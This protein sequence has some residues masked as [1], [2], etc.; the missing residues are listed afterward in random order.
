M[1]LCSQYDHLLCKYRKKD[2][3]ARENAPVRMYTRAGEAGNYP[4]AS[5][6]RMKKG[7]RR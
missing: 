7:M 4:G 1:F 3:E 5:M 2:K 6:E